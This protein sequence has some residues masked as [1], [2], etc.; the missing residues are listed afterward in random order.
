MTSE[1]VLSHAFLA[2]YHLAALLA[3]EPSVD[4]TTVCVCGK[5][6]SFD[7]ESEISS[8][9]SHGSFMSV[10]RAAKL[11]ADQ[12]SHHLYLLQHSKRNMHLGACTQAWAMKCC[13]RVNTRHIKPPM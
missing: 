10:V 4:A 6:D 1:S 12:V 5:G 8:V 9:T 11:A 13:L 2:L 7:I 3:Q